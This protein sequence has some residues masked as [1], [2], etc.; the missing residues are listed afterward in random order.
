VFATIY[1]M[2]MHPKR[3]YLLRACYEWILDNHCTPCIIVDVDYL[4]AQV[5]QNHVTDGRIILNIAPRAVNDFHMS[6]ELVT[7]S[8]RFGGVPVDI[9]LSPKAILGIYTQENGEGMIFESEYSEDEPPPEPPRD[10]KG[11]GQSTAKGQNAT[12]PSTG[13]KSSLRVVK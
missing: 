11:S 4:D 2:K 7:F 8:T 12:N 1:N 3:P 13:R 10:F 9:N 5:P 6:N